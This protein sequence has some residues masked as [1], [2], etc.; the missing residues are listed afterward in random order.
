[1]TKSI[2]IIV[3]GILI[4]LFGFTAYLGYKYYT[5]TNGQTKSI[6]PEDLGKLQEITIK[7]VVKKG[8]DLELQK[9]YCPDQLYILVDK[10]NTYI[11]GDQVF[12]LRTP[13]SLKVGATY[14]YA[15]YRESKVKI[16]AT[17][18]NL[19]ANCTGTQKDC[20]CDRFILVKDIEKL[21]NSFSTFPIFSGVISCL[22]DTAD[23]DCI[24]AFLDDG[25]NYYIL[26]NIADDLIVEG[27][28]LS[29]TGELAETPNSGDGVEG[30]IDVVEV[31]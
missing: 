18:Q 2:K 20:S 24:L 22:P 17:Y 9:S 31:K 6:T 25:G 11:G 23:E 21:G 10:G 28:E 7:G 12:Q 1:M 30:I 13:D 15:K 27:A 16:T 14:E 8:K 3:L 26:K 19:A 29:F 4:T 5:Q